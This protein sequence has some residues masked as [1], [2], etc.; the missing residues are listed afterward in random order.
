MALVAIG[1]SEVSSN[2]ITDSVNQQVTKGDELGYFQFG[3]STHCLVFKKG[4]IG[5]W[6][7]AATADSPSVIKLGLLLVLLPHPEEID[8]TG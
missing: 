8:D 1:M 2:I 4:V 6:S 5:S 7:P 3:G